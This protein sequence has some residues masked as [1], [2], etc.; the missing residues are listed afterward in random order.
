[1]WKSTQNRSKVCS[2]L[3]RSLFGES[4]NSS[5]TLQA[6]WFCEG[7]SVVFADAFAVYEDVFEGKY[8]RFPAV[9][10]AFVLHDAHFNVYAVPHDNVEVDSPLCVFRAYNLVAFKPV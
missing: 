6:E 7:G 10:E 5:L 2:L 3:H 1:M 4:C 9:A 8:H